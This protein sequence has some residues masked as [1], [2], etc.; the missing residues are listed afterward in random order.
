[1]KILT[2]FT[3]LLLLI[4]LVAC[5]FGVPIVKKKR[6]Y[7]QV[8]FQS[9]NNWKHGNIVLGYKAFLATCD[10]LETGRFPNSALFRENKNIWLSKCTLAK[11]YANNPKQFF[12]QNFIPYLVEGENGYNGTFTGYY[13]IELSGSRTPSEKFRYPVYGLPKDKSLQNLSRAEIEAGAL[14]GKAPVLAYAESK[15]RLYFMQIQ[16]TGRIIEP[17][18]NIIH[19]G[20]AG[21]NGYQYKSF[22]TDAIEQGL[23]RRD[24]LSATKMMEWID[25]NPQISFKELLKNPRFI[26]FEYR[27]NSPR[28]SL[29]VDLTPM[30]SIAVDPEYI[31]LG[32]PVWVETTYPPV[33]IKDLPKN[34]NFLVNAQDTGAAIK[35]VVRADIFFGS[36]EFA[37]KVSSGMKQQGRYYI[38]IPKELKIN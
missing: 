5:E 6:E 31:P 24:E 11:R 23:I 2:T 17:N 36:G 16:G 18:G 1:M 13:E 35:G 25:R 32:S 21:N 8:G 37:E 28:G 34:L 7:K 26:F 14:K 38:L 10:M 19:F 22:A 3:A 15:G 33:G 29:G 30:G 20:Y 12:E 9:L 27:N 4:S